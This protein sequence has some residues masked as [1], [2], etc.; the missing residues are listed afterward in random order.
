MSEING[1]TVRKPKTT[2]R[3]R[4]YVFVVNQKTGGLILRQERSPFLGEFP[5]V[6]A[7]AI[8]V[9]FVVAS[10]CNY[11][12][13]H[14]QAQCYVENI[15]QLESEYYILSEQNDLTEKQLFDMVDLG[16]IYEVARNELGMTPAS[17]ENVL[18]YD[19]SN[20]EYIF[21]TEDI[22]FARNISAWAE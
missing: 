4:P 20:S 10:Y 7:F 2:N 22:P 18:V 21:Q 11:I 17:Q 12:N 15:S 3:P 19:R 8:S 5:Y 16:A 13:L 6:A 14:T 9:I 1:N